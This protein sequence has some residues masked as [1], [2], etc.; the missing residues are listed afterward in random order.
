MIIDIPSLSFCITCKNRFHQVQHTLLKNLGDNR[1]YKHLIEFVLVDFGSKDGLQ[2]WIKNNCIKYIKEGYLKYYY[3]DEL[4]HW[5][6]S[7]AKNT[8]HIYA[9]NSLLVNLDCDNFTGPNGGKYLIRQFMKLGEGIVLHQFS[10]DFKDGSYGR[11][12]VHR[13]YFMAI[14]GYDESF[15]PMAYQDLDLIKRLLKSGL[16]YILIPDTRYNKAIRNTTTDSMKNTNSELE[17]AQMDLIN[18]IRSDTNALEARI[19]ANNNGF[20]IC[21]N[22]YDIYG[23]PALKKTLYE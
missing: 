18:K 5:H 10:G 3:T 23:N 19:R 22:I 12:A 7:I 2:D 13:K 6:A 1:M 21:K 17:W 11:I 14:R 16:K 9:S 15:E 8:A 4:T 20:G